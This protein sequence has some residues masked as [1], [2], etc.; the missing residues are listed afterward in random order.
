[1][2]EEAQEALRQVEAAGADTFDLHVL[3]AEAHRRRERFEAS[4][5][6]F[7]RALRLKGRV[8]IPYVCSRCLAEAPSW[9]ARCPSCGSWDTLRVRGHEELER[10][11]QAMPPLPVRAYQDA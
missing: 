9:N 6:E 5:E 8:A 7:Q 2:V 10:A 4:V 11:R 3:L 1:M